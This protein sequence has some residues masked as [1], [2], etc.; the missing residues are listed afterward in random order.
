M[1]EG[2]A[3]AGEAF[4]F[5]AAFSADPNRDEQGDAYEEGETVLS[6]EGSEWR[7]VS[8][9]MWCFIASGGAG[10][11][12]GMTGKACGRSE[13]RFCWVREA[14]SKRSSCPREPSCAARH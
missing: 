11:K 3:G 10:G 9:W 7:V 8:H 1:D 4:H 12:H 13:G 14:T 5:L 2:E 6:G